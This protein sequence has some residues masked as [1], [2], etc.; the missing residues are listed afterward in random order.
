MMI[1][2][3]V[4]RRG[5]GATSLETLGLTEGSPTHQPNMLRSAV[6]KVQN[7][8]FPNWRHCAKSEVRQTI[9]LRASDTIVHTALRASSAVVIA[10][11]FAL[12]KRTA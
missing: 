1:I 10:P 6:Y 5:F 9:V 8:L 3:A 4:W 2:P 7:Y 12:P 11:W